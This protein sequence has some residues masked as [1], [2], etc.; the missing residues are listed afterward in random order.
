[1]TDEPT[2][3]SVVVTKAVRLVAPFVF[4]FGLFV[5]FHGASSVGGG[6][7]GGV[8]VASVVVTIA[9][10]FGV[11]QTARWLD[12]AVLTTC[13]TLGVVAFAA[14]GV[15]P[16]AFGGTPFE[17]TA[18]PG[19]KGPL[20]AVEVVEVGIGVTVAATVVVLFVEISGGFGG[21]AAAGPGNGDASDTEE[22]SG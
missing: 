19:A 15:G 1:M 6:F 17:L 13:G 10:A 5:T 7:Q 9:F 18:Y 4:T 22:G 11:D 14:V 3:E 2:R 20:Y 21:D 16:L 12:R 8:V